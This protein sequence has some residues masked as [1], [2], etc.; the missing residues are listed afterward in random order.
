MLDFLAHIESANNARL[1][2]YAPFVIDGCAVGLI[3]HTNVVR[4]NEQG[5]ALDVQEN[6]YHW[7]YDGDCQTRSAYLNDIILSL[8]TEGFVPGWR[9]EQYALSRDFYAPPKALIERASMPIFGACG[10]GVHVNG[11]TKKQGKTHLWIAKRADDKP[12]DPGKLDQIAAGGIPH[13]IDV[14]ANMQKECDEEA[15]I[16][17]SLSETATA[18]SMSSYFYAVENGIR[19]DQLFNYD[20]W[21]PESF[22][23]HNQ[24]GEVASFDC[25]PL[26]EVMELVSR[27]DQFKFNANIVLIDLFIRHGLIT[28]EHQQYE[29]IC[30]QLNHRE[31]IL[32]ARFPVFTKK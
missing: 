30:A 5:L 19:A 28:P 21:L 14:F 9:G 1:D 7:D 15:S 23:P 4:L 12:T 16:P 10:Y 31:A 20:L 13:G 25:L 26:E 6:A 24:D 27:T 18:V 2:D 29:Q 32:C 8:A 3:H 11:L 17:L 22:I